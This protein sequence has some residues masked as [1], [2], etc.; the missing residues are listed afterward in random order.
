MIS[1]D[2][3]R[4]LQQVPSGPDACTLSL[5]VNINQANQSNLNRGFITAVENMF[6]QMSEGQQNHRERLEAECR[7][8]LD[9]LANYTAGGKGL[10]IFSDS[11]RDLWWQRDLQVEVPTGARWTPH[12]WV[13]PLLEL[14]EEHDHFAVVLLDKQRARILT[15]DATGVT[16]QAEIESEVANR[17][18]ATGTD[19]IWSQSHMERNHT[20][21][22]VGHV[23]RVVEELSTIVDRTRVSRVIIGGPVEAASILVGELPKRLEQMVTGAI[24]VPIDANTERLMEEVRAVQ[25]RYEQEDESRLVESMITAA[26][27]GD[28]AVLGITD[29]LEAIQ[30][31][32]IYCMM[33]ARDYHI[34]GKECDSCHVLVVDGQEKCS[35]CGGKLEAAPDLINRA[36]YRVLEQSGKVQIISGAAAGKLERIG[37]GAVL[38]F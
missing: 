15:V 28:R 23:K 9:F 32:R 30:Q 2:D 18:Q 7:R 21:Q 34:E 31:Q 36:S 4:Q 17:H 12:P 19:H 8:V 13:R 27:K 24:S 37:V 26:H 1:Y 35:F 20:N 16:Q 14:I 33:V 6:R 29:T 11:S 22:V 38:R 5:Y 3:L 10:V 25:Q